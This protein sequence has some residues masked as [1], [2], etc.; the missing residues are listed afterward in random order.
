MNHFAY[1]HSLV[2]SKA[3]TQPRSLTRTDT[4]LHTW[5]HGQTDMQHLY[6]LFL[7]HLPPGHPSAYFCPILLLP[8]GQLKGGNG[9]LTEACHFML[10]HPGES[11]WESNGRAC[12]M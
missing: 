3:Q 8:E 1:L 10:F 12:Q 11:E 4:I 6:F 9:G 7:F 5:P 2:D